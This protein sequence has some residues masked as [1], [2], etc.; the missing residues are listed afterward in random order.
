[1]HSLQETLNRTPAWERHHARKYQ[2]LAVA[3]MNEMLAASTLSA[4]DLD[5]KAGWAPGFAR[6]L[7]AGGASLTLDA[8]ARFEHALGADLFTLTPLAPE[9]TP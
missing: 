6:E 1:M 7:L 9:A 3:R 4:A 2:L 8:V 5:A